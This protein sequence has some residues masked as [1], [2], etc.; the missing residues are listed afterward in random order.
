MPSRELTFLAAILFGSILGASEVTITVTEPTGVARSG[1]PVTSGIPLSQGELLRSRQAALFSAGGPEV[2]LQTEVLSRWPDG[3]VRWLLLDFQ[4][5][6]DADETKRFMLRYGPTV[7]RS[8]VTRPLQIALHPSHTNPIT[9]VLDAGPLRIILSTD[10]FRLLDSIWLDHDVDGEFSAAERLTD[11]EGAGIVLIGVDGTRY[12]ADLSLA[13]WTVEQHGPLRACVRIDGRHRAED[14][15]PM[16]SYVVRLHTFRGQSFFK[17]DY[18]FIND[19]Q[20]AL[21]AKIN[22]IEIVCATQEGGDR[23]LLNGEPI[24]Q[25]SRLF[26]VDDTQFEVNG[27]RSPGRAAG[28]AAIASDDGGLAVGVR[29]FWQNWPK[30]LQVEPGELRIGIC[31]DFPAGQYDGLPLLEEVKHYFYL[32]DGNYTLKIGAARTHQLWVNCY[33]GQ[34]D[35]EKLSNFYS[36]TEKP[37]LAQCTPEYVCGTGVVGDAPPADPDR[38]HGYDAWLDSMFDKHLDDQENLRENG[39]L[40]FGDWYDEKKFQGGWGNQE[41]DTSHCFFVQYLRT[42]DRRYFDRARQGAWHSMD[43]DVLHAINRHIR[44]L[45]HHGQPQP[46]HIW[47]HSVGHT[48]GY[49]EETSLGAGMHYQRGYLHDKGHVWIGGIDDCYCLTGNRRAGD[50]AILVADRVASECPTRYSDHIRDVGWPLNLMMTAYE[51]TGDDKYLAAAGRQWEELRANLHPQ[52][53][54]ITMLAYGHCSMKDEGERCHGQVSYMLALTL[55]SLTRYHQATGDPE[56]LQAI[57]TGLD[58]IIRTCWSEEHL[59]FYGTPCTH[60]HDRPPGDYSPTTFLSSLA[61]A[62]EIEQ[63][64]NQEHARIFR[65]A[66]ATAMNGGKALLETADVQAQ[67]GYAS[68]AFHFTAYGL[69]ALETE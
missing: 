32:R 43:V 56:V 11:G 63:T 37:L 55:S 33:S 38:Y 59:S 27:D 69:R 50:V 30:S 25:P 29:D 36:A 21:M 53:G 31:P 34:P 18:T 42:G 22:A 54:W 58:Q 20:D 16:F 45:D 13:T 68:R 39:L 51:L 60:V 48:G 47:T 66:F 24:S 19:H 52:R 57:S 35:A 44:G 41:Y 28:W 2:P 23:L 26:Q 1:W 65:Q 61:F 9:P 7:Q 5:D 3:S 10:H 62:H 40:N 4:V 8:A 17:F 49:Y 46:G 6:L 12:R 14:G 15:S 64:G 67:A